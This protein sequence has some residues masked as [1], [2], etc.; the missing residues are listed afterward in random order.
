MKKF[1]FEAKKTGMSS[2]PL[3]AGGYVAKI[4]NALIKTY[5]WG[6][7][8]VVS[9]D[10]DDGEYKDFFRQ[11]FKNSP[12]EDKKWKG[13][14]RVT[15]PDKS[16]QWYESQLKRFGNLIAC[17]EESNDGYH[18][19]WDET[20]LKGKRVGVLFREREWAYN[21]N[22]GWTTEACSILSVQDI[23]N[24]KFKTPKAKPLPASQ[25]PAA[26]ESNADFE[27][28]DDGDDDDLPF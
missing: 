2:D 23:Q 1:D 7:V 19:D 24:G 15:V 10:I 18:W 6:E 17:L 28:I 8:L 9:F 16:N 5:D 21:G 14:I 26:V 3:P 20:A 4:V 25:K 22:T 12:F 13:N 27:V 11:Q